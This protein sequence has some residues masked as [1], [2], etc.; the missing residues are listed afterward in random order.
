VPTIAV[1]KPGILT[2]HESD[3]NMVK[4]FVSSGSVSMNIDGSCQILAEEIAPVDNLDSQ[5]IPYSF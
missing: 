3:G 1:L 2:V 4:F 5:V